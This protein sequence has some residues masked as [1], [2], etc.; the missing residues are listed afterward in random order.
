MYLD[1]L[2]SSNFNETL[3]SSADHSTYKYV[4]DEHCMI[5]LKKITITLTAFH[6]EHLFHLRLSPFQPSILLSI[7]K[8]KQENEF[9]YSQLSLRWIPL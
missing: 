2:S 4:V 7:G 3:I 5:I 9:K 1:T 6:F 8:K